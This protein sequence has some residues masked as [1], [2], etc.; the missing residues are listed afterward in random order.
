MENIQ[1]G[2]FGMFFFSINQMTTLFTIEKV[3]KNS[4]HYDFVFV[5]SFSLKRVKFFRNVPLF[6][7]IPYIQIK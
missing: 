2:Y 4:S 6:L 7:S 1:S 5:T 3:S